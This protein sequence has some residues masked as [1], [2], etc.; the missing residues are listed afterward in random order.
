MVIR[1]LVTWLV[2]L[3]WG[4]VAPHIG[5]PTAPR[6]D[7]AAGRLYLA[8]TRTV[9]I[10]PGDLAYSGEARY[11]WPNGRSYQGGWKQG[12][13]H[14]V[15]SE[16]LPNGER[17]H[18]MWQQGARHGHGELT[19]T[20]G[21]RY[22]G[23]FE[24]GVRHGEGVERSTAGLYR[25]NWLKD[26]PNGQGAYHSTDGARYDGEWF[27][28]LRHGV[29]TYTD[30][31][32]NHYEGDWLRD[33][34][35]G[36]GTMTSPDESS[37]EGE[38]VAGTRV[39]YGR[40]VDTSGLV[41]EGTWVAGKRQGFGRE[42]RPDGSVYQGEWHNGKSH[43]QG[44][45]THADGSFHD[46][47][48]ENNVVLGPGTRRTSTGVEISGVWNGDNVSMGLLLLPTGH[49]YA[50]PLFK[51]R[52]TE[53]SVSLVDW[54]T[55]LADLG[56]PYAQ[57]LIGTVYSDFTL[58]RKNPE[59]ARDYFGKAA[60]S[61]L[62]EAQFRLARIEIKNNVPRAIEMLSNAAEQ[63]HPRANDLLGEYYHLGKHVPENQERAIGYYEHALANGSLTARNNLAWLLATCPDPE[64][65]DG[66]RAI[67]LIKPI[68]LLYG[69]WQHLDTLAA[70]F[71]EQGLFA[72]AVHT[73]KE[74]LDKIQLDDVEGDTSGVIVEMQLRM[75]L[76]RAASPF[77][78]RAR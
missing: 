41:Y 44:K 68:A 64:V 1:I 51:H 40:L 66:A 47:Q 61:G 60:G 75:E 71:A 35:H 73:Q 2:L 46:G 34:P 20:D 18:G 30:A 74:A 49:Q 77:H 16:F 65:R 38:W 72:D 37:Y 21:S 17:Y 76:F 36:F 11:E 53:V 3:Q 48:W 6:N 63:N 15:G 56:D 42:Q 23:G 43:G 19:R 24:A 59:R 29:G 27:N 45:E 28:G 12:L 58:P 78:E 10:Y 54:L 25:G 57:L 52:N 7:P 70:A 67:G 62:A 50:G 5:G 22:L 9:W 33:N 4:C 14:G 32:G 55:D 26:L 39:G 8:K 31:E 69:N 13:P